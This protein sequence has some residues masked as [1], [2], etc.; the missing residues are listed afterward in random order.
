[1]FSLQIFIIWVA[2]VSVS[3]LDAVNGSEPVAEECQER[4]KKYGITHVSDYMA[5][6]FCSLSCG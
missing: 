6:C 4:L 1:M 2:I 5:A 3:T